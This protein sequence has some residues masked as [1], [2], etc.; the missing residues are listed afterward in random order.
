[1]G[2]LLSELSLGELRTEFMK[3]GLQGDFS[4]GLAIVRL[5]V[6]L[7]NSG[8]D[9]YTYQ[10]DSVSVLGMVVEPYDQE[11][12]DDNFG[13]VPSL[14]ELFESTVSVPEAGGMEPVPNE[15]DDTS[16]D[17][18]DTLG[19][20]ESKESKEVKDEPSDAVYSNGKAVAVSVIGIKDEPYDAVEHSTG[21]AVVP[22]ILNASLCALSLPLSRCSRPSQRTCVVCGSM[23]KKKQKFQAPQPQSRIE[24]VTICGIECGDVISWIMKPEFWPPKPLCQLGTTLIASLDSC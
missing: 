16:F 9:P 11:V 8:L 24:M 17:D 14:A 6:Y 20:I 7:I 21:K 22:W 4:E 10:F 19:C 5:V 13:S 2:K 1:M 18:E 3:A 12:H 15:V 23:L